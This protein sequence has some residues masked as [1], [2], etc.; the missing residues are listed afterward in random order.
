MKMSRFSESLIEEANPIWQ[1]IFNHPFLHELGNGRLP[2]E[3]FR[4]Y[5]CQ[6]YRFL[7]DYCRFLGLATARS[8]SFD[9]MRH[10]SDMLHYEFTQEIAMQREL[11]TKVGLTIHDMKAT[12]ES[13]TTLAYTSYLLRIALTGSTGE[14][15]AALSPC[16]LTYTELAIRLNA[17]GIEKV[18][19]YAKWLQI[20]QSAD[21]HQASEKLKECLDDLGETSTKSQN[22]QMMK[23]FLTASRY[24]YLFWQ[25]AY[26]LEKWPI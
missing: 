24:E 3:K 20:Y 23:S 22:L 5:I 9:K 2:V 16:P 26:T 1:K 4:Y 17:Q 8:K 6:D 11:A 21:T 19:A 13:P 14:I 15:F 18:P 7:F 25:M 12:E 10:L